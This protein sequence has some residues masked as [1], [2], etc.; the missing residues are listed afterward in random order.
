MPQPSENWL[1]VAA[2]LGTLGGVAI[3][4]FVAAYAKARAEARAGV[5][6]GPEIA[7]SAVGAAFVDRAAAQAI[8]GIASDVHGIHDLVRERAELEHDDRLVRR[9]ADLLRNKPPDD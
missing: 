1:T 8:V 6:R 4:A 9:T 2:W 5:D 7:A 3:A